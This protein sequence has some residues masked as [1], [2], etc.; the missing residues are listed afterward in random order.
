MSDLA[1]TDGML[2]A[3]MREIRRLVDVY[4][5]TERHPSLKPFHITGPFAR[6]KIG[7]PPELDGPGCYVIYGQGGV[8]RYVGMSLSRVGTRI[9][10]HLSAKTQS[11]PFWTKCP[12]AYVD[13]IP[14]EK[15][16]QSLSLE[17]F[18]ID[19]TASLTGVPPLVEPS[20]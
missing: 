20:D 15:S 17:G 4:C 12:A 19:E 11:H 9:V 3:D 5:A 7:R 8:C 18:L 10:S 13:L 14:V 2:S 6:D 1:F 16:W